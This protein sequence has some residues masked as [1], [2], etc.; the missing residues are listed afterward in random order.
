V[1]L[2]VVA[3]TVPF[4]VKPLRVPTDVIAGWAAF[5]TVAAEPVILPLIVEL[6][7]KPVKVPTEVI[8]GC[9]AVVIVPPSVVP[10]MLPEANM[11]VGVISPSV[12]V[13][14]G[15][16]VEFATTPL[17]PLAV[18]TDTDVTVPPAVMVAHVLSPR[19]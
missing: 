1:P 7:V 15:V 19:K 11:E 3:D 18:T 16:L 10:V 5:V 12:K 8:F 9:A 13:I 2:N 4:T 6:T 17:T 14:A